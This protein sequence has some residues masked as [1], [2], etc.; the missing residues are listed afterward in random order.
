MNVQ[1][2]ASDTFTASPNQCFSPAPPE[3][4]NAPNYLKVSEIAATLRLSKTT[5]YQAISDGRLSVIQAGRSNRGVRVAKSELI[6]WIGGD[7]R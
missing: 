6:R 7:A 1:R 2:I 4:V 5:I 3:L